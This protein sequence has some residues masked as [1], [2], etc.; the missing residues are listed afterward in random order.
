MN[1]LIPYK[2]ESDTEELRYTLRSIAKYTTGA[3]VFISGDLPDWC[4]GVYHIKNKRYKD[5]VGPNRF[6]DVER[7]VRAFCE[8]LPNEDFLYMNDDFF[9]MRNFRYREYNRGI[10]NPPMDVSSPYVL[11]QKR[12]KRLL[13]KVGSNTSTSYELHMPM[14]MSAIKRLGISYV[15]GPK[16]SNGYTVLMRSIYGN[17]FNVGGKKIDDCKDI[18]DYKN[19]PFLSTSHEAWKGELGNYIRSKFD[20]P[21]IYER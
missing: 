5:L 14:T 16:M 19:K 21:S 6:I 11:A 3:R 18:S 15:F 8:L 4:V 7:K 13:S 10:L 17:L 2:I 12:T 9:I 1:I 20:E